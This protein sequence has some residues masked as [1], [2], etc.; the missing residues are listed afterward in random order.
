MTDYALGTGRRRHARSSVRRVLVPLSIA[1]L[2]ALAGAPVA[3][4]LWPQTQPASP[5]APSLPITIGGAT[6]NAPPAA[7]RFKMQRRAGPQPRIDLMFR[8]PTLEPPGPAAALTLADAPKVTERIFITIAGSD[9]TLPP[10]ERLQTIY[11]RYL[12][13]DPATEMD[14]LQVRAFRGGTPYH[15]EDLILD[16][17][18][19]ERL[20]MRCTRSQPATPGTCLHERRIAGADL[21]VRFPRDWLADWRAVADGVDKLIARMRSG[22]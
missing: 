11:P 8:W 6:F 18:A 9:N 7:I 5:D 17:G 2:A 3:Y 15:G 12:A 16:P 20:L 19:P 13:A 1:L 4:M 10:A 14:G 21:T 22:G